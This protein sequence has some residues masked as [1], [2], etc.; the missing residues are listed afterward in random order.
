[1]ALVTF[2]AGCGTPQVTTW[3]PLWPLAP[4]CWLAAAFSSRCQT[5]SPATRTQRPRIGQGGRLRG[6]CPTVCPTGAVWRLQS[7]SASRREK[8]W[9]D[10][11]VMMDFSLRT[12]RCLDPGLPMTSDGPQDTAASGVG[13]RPHI[14]VTSSFPSVACSQN[15]SRFSPSCW[16]PPTKSQASFVASLIPAIMLRGTWSQ[17]QEE[18]GGGTHYSDW[19]GGWRAGVLAPENWG[20]VFTYPPAGVILLVLRCSQL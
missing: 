13:R 10:V 6:S 2:Q 11:H 18:G 17:L 19:G 4:S 16:H 12:H 9:G 14:T 7:R 5:S 15:V 1:M 8:P 20:P 3:P